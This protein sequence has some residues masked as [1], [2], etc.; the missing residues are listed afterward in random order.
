[1]KALVILL[2]FFNCA[3]LWSQETGKTGAL[4]VP[5]QEEIF[6]VCDLGAE[7]PGGHSALMK[8]L[9]NNIRYP[10]KLGDVCYSTKV[11]VQFVVSAEG[12]VVAPKIM[13]GAVDCP[14]CDEEVLRV[15][16]LL[17]DFIP[18]KVQGKAVNSYFNLPVR[19]CHL[20]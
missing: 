2:L 18:A 12:K 1:M 17:P 16:K 14:E 5:D 3:N 20:E 19:F 8:F 9:A 13:R 6:F 4:A 7:F 15:I 10:A 11:Y